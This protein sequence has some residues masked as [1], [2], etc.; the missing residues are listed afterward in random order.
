MHQEQVRQ[1]TRVP[2]LIA[3]ILL[4]LLVVPSCAYLYFV[5]YRRAAHLVIVNRT[6]ET[7][8]SVDLAIS[9]ADGSSLPSSVAGIPPGG[10]VWLSCYRASLVSVFLASCRLSPDRTI[11][12]RP[13]GN[14]L[15]IGPGE[16]VQLV[17]TPDGWVLEER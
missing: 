5:V 9:T 14:C 10:E 12:F 2:R 11:V 13:P 17:V 6:R 1:S 7:V 3:T 15:L 16:T 4:S 8:A